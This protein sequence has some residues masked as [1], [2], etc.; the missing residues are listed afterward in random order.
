VIYFAGDFHLGT[1]DAR[2]SGEREKKICRWLNEIAADATEIYLLGDVFDFWFEYKTTVPK[3]FV[4]FL[5]TLAALTDRGIKITIFKGNHDMWMFGYLE[6]ECG[7]T[8]VSDELLIERSGV[9][10]FLHHGDGL[11]PGDCSYKFIRAVFRSALCQWFFARIHPNLGISLGIWL[12][13]KSRISQKSRKEEYHGDDR[14][15]LTIYSKEKLKTTAVDYFIYGHRHLVLD[16]DLGN[17]SR[18]INAGEWVHDQAYARFDGKQVQLLRY[19]E[20]Q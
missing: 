19:S 4:R 20:S 5:G 17:G 9:K 16:V 18:Y 14:E 15:I 3:G 13:R 2:Q 7:V 8:I 10:F 12:S 1:P 11:G 6:K